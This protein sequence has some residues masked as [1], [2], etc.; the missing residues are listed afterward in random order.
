MIKKDL[1]HWKKNL[2]HFIRFGNI[3][4]LFSS[5]ILCDVPRSTSFV[6]NG[7][8]VVLGCNVRLGKNCTIYQ[9]VIIGSNTRG[10]GYVLIGDN[11]VIHPFSVITG[12]ICIGSNACIGAF[13]FVNRDV[14]PGSVVYGIPFNVKE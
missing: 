6:H 4:M 1:W 12:N 10:E 7:Q 3:R 2:Q 5:D 8:G 9:N 13:S 14:S 11:V